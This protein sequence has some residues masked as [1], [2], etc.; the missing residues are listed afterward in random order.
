MFENVKKN[1]F[2]SGVIVG[3]FILVITLIVYYICNALDL[4]TIS[5]VIALGFLLL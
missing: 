1:K 4:G 3:I 2:Q 5:I